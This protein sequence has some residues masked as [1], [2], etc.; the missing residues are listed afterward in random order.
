MSLCQHIHSFYSFCPCSSSSTAETSCSPRWSLKEWTLVPNNDQK[1]ATYLHVS[2]NMFSLS[3]RQKAACCVAG[4]CFIS[5]L[6]S[7]QLPS[8]RLL[9]S[10][11]ASQYSKAAPSFRLLCSLGPVNTLKQISLCGCISIP[12]SSFLSLFPLHHLL[13]HLWVRSAISHSSLPV[14]SLLKVHR[15]VL[16]L[17]VLWGVQDNTGLS[18]DPCRT[19]GKRDKVGYR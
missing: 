4:G 19:R 11:G 5:P 14:S 12:L 16:R 17:W 8:P 7:E 15:T 10:L 2:S 6:L 18:T 3:A 1:R 13:G 9:S